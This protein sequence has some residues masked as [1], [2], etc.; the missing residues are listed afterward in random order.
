MPVC[1][2]PRRWAVPGI[3]FP[4]EFQE[5]SRDGGRVLFQAGTVSGGKVGQQY[6]GFTFYKCRASCHVNRNG[7]VKNQASG[8]T[9]CIST[10][11]GSYAPGLANTFPTLCSAGTYSDTAG[12]ASCTP[13]LPPAA[14]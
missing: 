3:S 1:M 5:S 8:L 4:R 12:A 13:A 9:A 14:S 6:C 2:R 7:N 11:P 10:L